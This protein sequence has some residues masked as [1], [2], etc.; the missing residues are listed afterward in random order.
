MYISPPSGYPTPE[1]IR[2]PEVRTEVWGLIYRTG[3]NAP[4][5]DVLLR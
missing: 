3:G 1:G 5:G 2:T 4:R